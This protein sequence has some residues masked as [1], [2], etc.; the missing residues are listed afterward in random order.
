MTD[1]VLRQLPSPPRSAARRKPRG[2]A[3]T[4]LQLRD[5]AFAA[6]TRMGTRLFLPE[7]ITLPSPPPKH[8]F[9]GPEAFLCTG[10]W[11]FHC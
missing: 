9:G 1:L 4:I 5:D 8:A 10:S 6:L 3:G 7:Q 2:R 11:Y